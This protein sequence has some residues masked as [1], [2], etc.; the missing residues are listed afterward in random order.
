VRFRVPHVAE[1]DAIRAVHAAVRVQRGF[2][3]F[4]DARHEVAR[5]IGLR[6]ALN[7]GEVVVSDDHRA[8]IAD[9][10]TVAARLQQEAQ[11]GDVLIGEATAHLVRERVTLDDV[12]TFSLKGRAETVT[13][14]RVVSLERPAGTATL[15]FVG[16]DEEMRRLTA[17]YEA[18]AAGPRTRLAVIL[19]SPGLGKSRLMAAFA[20]AR[21]APGESDGGSWHR[22]A[23]RG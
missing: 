3:A 21:G 20:R 13:A 9:P 1:D 2:R 18:A 23:L 14:Y 8:G 5:G 10:L 16:R 11:D 19:A 15:A 4:A 6:V 12:G 22:R 17:V 7:T